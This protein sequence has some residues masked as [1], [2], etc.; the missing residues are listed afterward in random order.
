MDEGIPKQGARG[1]RS[2]A[3]TV[4]GGRRRVDQDIPRRGSPAGLWYRRS[5][6]AR[7]KPARGRGNRISRQ[8]DKKKA[9]YVVKIRERRRSAR[10]SPNAGLRR[11]VVATSSA[12]DGWARS[13]CHE[14][15]CCSSFGWR[16][17][18]AQGQ[19]SLRRAEDY[20][21]AARAFCNHHFSP[22]S[23]VGYRYIG[24]PLFVLFARGETSR[25]F[26]RN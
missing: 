19:I 12:G 25:S 10:P 14:R 4:M 13:G 20:R 15:R 18:T 21:R 23:T 7:E 5:R 26:E 24:T 1:H 6:K 17:G 22:A 11:F 2:G 9:E 3:T 8:N 16:T